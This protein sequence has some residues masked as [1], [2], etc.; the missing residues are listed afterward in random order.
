MIPSRLNNWIDRRWFATGGEK[1]LVYI[2]FSPTFAATFVYRD[3]W[4][5]GAIVTALILTYVL[6]RGYLVG[7]SFMRS[8]D[9]AR[10]DWASKHQSREYRNSKQR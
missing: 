10:D 6:R 1:H 7:R 5:I 3:Y 2:A 9:K 8:T 4:W